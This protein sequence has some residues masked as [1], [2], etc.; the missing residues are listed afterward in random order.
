MT[1]QVRPKIVKCGSTYDRL[2]YSLT[3]F[4][5]TVKFALKE[6]DARRGSTRTRHEQTGDDSVDVIFAIDVQKIVANSSKSTTK[7]DKKS[8]GDETINN[9]CTFMGVHAG[10]SIAIPH[11]VLKAYSFISQWRKASMT[12]IDPML[13]ELAGEMNTWASNQASS[14]AVAFATPDA[15]TASS[16]ATRVTNKFSMQFYIVK[17]VC[18]AEILTSLCVVNVSRGIMARYV[19]EQKLK[20]NVILEHNRE[21]HYFGYIR[22]HCFEFFSRVVFND[23][24]QAENSGKLVLPTFQATGTRHYIR[25]ADPARKKGDAFE[26]AAVPTAVRTDVGIFVDLLSMRLDI[27]TIDYIITTLLLATNDVREILHVLSKHYNQ[28]DAAMSPSTKR[29]AATEHPVKSL[30]S[31]RAASRGFVIQAEIRR[32]PRLFC[33]PVLSMVS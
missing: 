25:K 4:N 23:T 15:E 14:P 19:T 5:Q 30:Y 16:R 9:M 6:M 33:N 21:T 11:T 12:E 3:A 10:E 2:V 31:L 18:K 28:Q 20:N 32:I 22:Y 7:I 24:H 26:A 27:D 13:H 29:I 1:S 8:E 17:F